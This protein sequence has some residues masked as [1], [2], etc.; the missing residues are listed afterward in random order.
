MYISEYLCD[1]YLDV[2]KDGVTGM[3]K[4]TNGFDCLW[5]S[6]RATHGVSGGKVWNC[7]LVSCYHWA[8]FV[9]V[10]VRF[11]VLFVCSS[12][13]CWSLTFYLQEETQ[14][15]TFFSQE[16]WIGSCF[17]KFEMCFILKAT[18]LSRLAMITLCADCSS[19][20]STNIAASYIDRL[21]FNQLSLFFF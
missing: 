7:S 21:V 3:P 19:T 6:L 5:A 1:L 13:L 4:S 17:I 16:L 10:P 14:I 9:V 11:C 8:R 15:L 12:V 18:L 2:D 20:G